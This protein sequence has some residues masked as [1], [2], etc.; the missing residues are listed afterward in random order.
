MHVILR[1]ITKPDDRAAGVRFVYYKP[2]TMTFFA[3]IRN[4][5]FLWPLLIPDSRILGQF[6]FQA[7]PGNM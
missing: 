7:P 1:V 5:D 3:A 4:K 6:K 2:V